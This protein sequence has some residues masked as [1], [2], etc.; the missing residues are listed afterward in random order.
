MPFFAV[1]G[2]IDSVVYGRPLTLLGCAEL[3]VDLL[4]TLLAVA[5]VLMLTLLAN[6]LRATSLFVIEARLVPHAPAWWHEGIGVV[7]FACA[8]TAILFLL[9]RLKA[10]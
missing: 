2:S 6:V 4:R 10:S 1:C 9:Q 7:S 5:S 3:R 8:G